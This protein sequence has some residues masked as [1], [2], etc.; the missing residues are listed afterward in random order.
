MIFLTGEQDLERMM[1]IIIPLRVIQPR[2]LV[3]DTAWNVATIRRPEILWPEIVGGVVVVL[4][5]QMDESIA[6]ETI[7]NTLSEFSQNIGM[8]IILN[9]VDRIEA[10]T[11]EVVLLEPVESVVDEVVANGPA[12]STIE[13]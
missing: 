12:L 10:E 1:E 4:Q 2:L 8:R 9:G 5:N 3:R 13:I 7:A 6:P 11:I